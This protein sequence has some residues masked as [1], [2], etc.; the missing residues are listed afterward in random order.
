VFKNAKSLVEKKKTG[1]TKSQNRCFLALESA[2][3]FFGFHDQL[4]SCS[5]SSNGAE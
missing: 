4:Q 5:S 1:I 3:G 2:G